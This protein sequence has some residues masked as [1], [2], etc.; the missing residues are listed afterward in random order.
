[1]GEP[2]DTYNAVM[3]N[4]FQNTSNIVVNSYLYADSKKMDSIGRGSK[5]V[6]QLSN[7]TKRVSSWR[8]LKGNKKE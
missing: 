5:E 3:P 4:L 6:K 1:M 8:V 2:G 7:S